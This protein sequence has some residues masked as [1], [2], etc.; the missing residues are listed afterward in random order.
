MK[1]CYHTLSFH[2]CGLAVNFR[3]RFFPQ[4]KIVGALPQ[5]AN[6]S[7]SAGPVGPALLALHK[8]HNTVPLGKLDL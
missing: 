3:Q 6:S 8:T 5:S 1:M 2:S 7:K 4:R